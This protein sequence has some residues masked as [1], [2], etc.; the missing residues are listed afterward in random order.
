VCVFFFFGFPCFFPK[1]LEILIN[2]QSKLTLHG[3][4]QYYVELQEQEKNRKLVDLLDSL[5]FNQ[6]VIFVRSVARASELNRLLVECNFP[7]ICIHSR[8]NQE[9]RIERY[10]QFK[11][12]RAR[13]MVATNLF[14]R[15]IDIERVNVVF[16][17]DMP[18]DADNYLHRVGRAGRFG[19][20]GLSISFVSSEDDGKVLNDV[21]R[22][23]FLSVLVVCFSDLLCVEALSICSSMLSF[24]GVSSCVGARV[25]VLLL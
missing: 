11:D 16:N 19:T 5:E 23:V 10:R 17:Y 7:S 20:K 13:L 21:Q 22:L 15:G 14:G 4:Q 3:L 24:S 9:T 18:G 1:P 2:D 25:C 8:M 12:F 6:C